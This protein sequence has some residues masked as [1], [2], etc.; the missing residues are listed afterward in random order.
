MTPDFITPIDYCEEF[1]IWIK[2]DDLYTFKTKNGIILSGGKVRNA[3]ILIEDAIKKGFK[4]I[5]SVGHRESPQLFIIGHL[6]KHFDLKFTG[7]TTMGILP[8]HLQ[9][10]NII[11]HKPGYNNVLEYRCKEFAKSNNVY[12]IP[13]GMVD[14][15][16]RGQLKGQI[17]NLPEKY[18]RIV[19]PVGSAVNLSNLI[20]ELSINNSKKKIIGVVIGKSPIKTLNFFAP[21]NW[22]S[23]CTLIE[24]KH[25]YSKK[26]HI[27]INGFDLDPVY[28]SK[29]MDFVQRN[30]LL[31]IIGKRN[32]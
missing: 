14:I 29:C 22:G 17:Y 6:C 11:Q 4:H 3:L 12:M 21:K 25:P 9:P 10:F 24:A 20:W 8:E 5:T 13:F 32:F 30:D 15:K 1:G 2:R 19:I 16:C 23:F 7:H 26:V 18:E 27:K 28:E 31:W